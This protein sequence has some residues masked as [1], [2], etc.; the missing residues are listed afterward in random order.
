LAVI[1][2]INHHEIKVVLKRL[3]DSPPAPAAVAQPMSENQRRSVGSPGSVDVN[4]YA[5]CIDITLLPVGHGLTRIS[6]HF[7]HNHDP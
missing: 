4:D 2:C 6:D 1:P 3:S 7:E 5:A